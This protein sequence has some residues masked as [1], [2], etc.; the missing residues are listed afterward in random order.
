MALI[1]RAG[2]SV[3]PFPKGDLAASAQDSGIQIGIG[4]VRLG[5]CQLVIL[6]GKCVVGTVAGEITDKSIE[7][8]LERE[9]K[10][11]GLG[12]SEDLLYQITAFDQI[13]LRFPE[14]AE[15]VG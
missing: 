13:V 5:K 6:F 7:G 10:D 1:F 9:R 3:V 12:M 11:I 15:A 14:Q 8:C 2:A 4:I